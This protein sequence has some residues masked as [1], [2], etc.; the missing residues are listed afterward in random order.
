MSH[1]IEWSKEIKIRKSEMMDW[2]NQRRIKCTHLYFNIS[3]FTNILKYQYFN[4]IQNINCL[5]I[6]E[7]VDDTFFSIC[8]QL[9]NLK[10]FAINP[11]FS[12]SLDEL[13]R[14]AES[15]PKLTDLKILSFIDEENNTYYVNDITALWPNLETCNV[16]N[17]RGYDNGNTILSCFP[18]LKDG[19]V[20][21]SIDSS[22]L[23]NSS[24][25]EKIC[26]S[27]PNIENLHLNSRFYNINGNDNELMSS[28][29]NVE[30]TQ[31]KYILFNSLYFHRNLLD[32]LSKMKRL[33]SIKV[34]INNRNN[35]NVNVNNNG[36]ITNFPFVTF[37]KM[38]SI[39]IIFNDRTSN[40]LELIN[41][42][43]MCNFLIPKCPNLLRFSFEL[44]SEGDSKFDFNLL[45][46][47][48]KDLSIKGVKSKMS[49]DF[50]KVSC[51]NITHL[52]I[53]GGLDE[54][55]WERSLVL[56]LSSLD[57][58]SHLKISNLSSYTL[59]S[60]MRVPY[61]SLMFMDICA[62]YRPNRVIDNIQDITPLDIN[63]ISPC[64]RCLDLRIFDLL[65]RPW[66][67]LF[68]NF[69]TIITLNIT[70]EYNPND[71]NITRNMIRS[72]LQYCQFLKYLTFQNT[73]MYYGISAI[74][75]SGLKYLESIKVI[76]AVKFK[77]MKKDIILDILPCPSLK[78][79]VFDGSMIDDNNIKF[80]SMAS[81]NLQKLSISECQNITD[82]SLSYI[83]ENNKQLQKID[84]S[85]CRRITQVGLIKLMS[86]FPKLQIV[87][88]YQCKALLRSNNTN[89]RMKTDTNEVEVKENI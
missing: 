64:M 54:G 77:I 68:S 6:I 17:V 11:T 31:V 33:E 32:F 87:S 40:V 85:S 34:D 52:T 28:S 9:V 55:L 24:L 56:A 60:I 25:L 88:F 65:N 1:D 84:F 36:M 21:I 81:P 59:E 51:I 72:I 61:K 46:S 18:N 20:E 73:C 7:K 29:R 89:K 58:L 75:E 66:N 49:F 74:C 69:S 71:I 22:N 39:E 13:R 2:L 44:A 12:F 23:M 83:C 57:F 50:L 8:K 26:H 38:E 10:S 78:E 76:D 43:T 80:I 63:C 86:T 15:C 37:D 62:T 48:L 16:S 27:F 30:F 45:S 82:T 47:S 35:S 42:D 4:E 14:L 53:I 41:L 67:V 19:H 5:S 79:I 3:I 70:L